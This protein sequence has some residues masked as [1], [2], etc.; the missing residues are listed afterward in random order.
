MHS[1]S[2]DQSYDYKGKRVAAVGNGSSGIQ[3][4]PALLPEVP[5]IDYYTRGRTW[6]SPSFRREQI[7][8]RG[9]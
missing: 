7:E 9:Q 2:W 1:A 3:I 8:K 5:H 4:V 6:I